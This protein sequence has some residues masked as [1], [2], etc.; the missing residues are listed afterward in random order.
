MLVLSLFNRLVIPSLASV[1][2][3][4]HIQ[5]LGSTAFCDEMAEGE[6]VSDQRQCIQC[7]M[8]D[9]FADTI[10]NLEHPNLSLSPDEKRLFGQLFTAADTEGLGVVT[11]EVAVKQFEKTRLSSAVLGEVSL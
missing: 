4:A 6:R 2:V 9:T 8:Y 11:G 10:I 3:T 1:T 7:F 5:S